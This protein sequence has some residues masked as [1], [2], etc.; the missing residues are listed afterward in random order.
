MNEFIKQNR[1]F[2]SQFKIKNGDKKLLIEEPGRVMIVH[3]NA[4]FAMIINQA[5]GYVPVWLCEDK[6]KDFKLLRSYFPDIEI[7]VFAKNSLVRKLRKLYAIITAITKFPKIYFT[8][9]ILEFCYDKVKYGDIL[10]DSYLHENRV[11]TIKKIDY[12]LLKLSA[13]CI[14]RHLTIKGVLKRGDYAGVLVSHMVGIE[15]GVMLRT[16]LRYGYEV[17]LRTGHHVSR[18]QRLKGIEEAYDYPTKATPTEIDGIIAQLGSKLEE[19]FSET[20]QKE[21]SGRGNPNSLRA[22]SGENRHYSDR[23]SFNKKYKLDPNKK[24]VFVMLHVFNDHPHSHFHWMLFRDYYDWFVQ[25]LNFAKKNNRVNWIFKQHP[26]VRNY[27]TKDVC[28]D[29][30]FSNCPDHIVYINED[31][32]IDTRSL[33]CCA[34]LVVTCLGSSGFELPAMGAIPSLVAG[35]NPYTDLGFTV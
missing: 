11:A 34:D 31:N 23:E 29:N 5:R 3:L 17:Y 18:L 30:L 21:V 10:Y 1:E 26:S 12:K 8:K 19:K 24:N 25:T 16:A 7:I 27:V 6:F 2:W 33:V 13:I 22:F 9:N 4:I 28:I 20:L 15:S 32:Q 14:F 35:D